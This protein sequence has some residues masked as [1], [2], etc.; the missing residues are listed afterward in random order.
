M[1][2]A[3]ATHLFYS[4]ITLVRTKRYLAWPGPG[5]RPS[6]GV[7]VVGGGPKLRMGEMIPSKAQWT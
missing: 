4:I 5:H 3:V 1:D 6:V 7:G 2:L